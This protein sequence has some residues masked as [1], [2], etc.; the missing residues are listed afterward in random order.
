M[1]QIYAILDNL[2]T[3]RAPDVL[4]FALTLPRWERIFQPKYAASLNLIEPWWKALRS[5][6]LWLA[7]AG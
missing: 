7:M 5:G 6:W 4:L 1:E 3:H 2:S